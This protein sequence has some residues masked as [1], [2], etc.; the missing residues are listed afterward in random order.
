[1]AD[2]WWVAMG[3]RPVDRDQLFLLPPSMRDWLPPGHLALLVEDLVEQM[4]TSVL[5]R[6][7][8][9]VGRAAYDPDMLLGLLVYGY[10]VGVRSSRQIEARCETDVAFRYLCAQDVPDHT[11]IARFRQGH[12]EALK[13]LLGGVLVVAVRLGMGRFG[14]IAIDGTKIEANASKAANAE[15]ATLRRLAAQLVDESIAVDEAEDELHG[16]DRG[17][18]LPPPVRDRSGR[19]ER[20]AAALAKAEQAQA[21]R[22]GADAAV[23][24]RTAE[25]VAAAEQA[26]AAVRAAQQA[27]VDQW[28]RRRAEDGICPPGA[29]P[30][31]VETAHQVGKATQRVA[32]AQARAAR[33]AAKA[34]GRRQ[35]TANRTDPDSRLLPTRGG[36]T[37]G[38][39]CMLSASD[40]QLITGYHIHDNPHDAAAFLPAMRDSEHR[41]AHAT[42]TAGQH[43]PA[44][45]TY[46]ADAGFDTDDNLTAEGPDRLIAERHR[47]HPS[48]PSQP[49]N[50][51]PPADATPR[52]AMA[53]RLATP[54]GRQ[55]Y[56]RRATT[57]EPVNAHLKDRIGLRRFLLRG[58][59]GALT[60]LG[61]AAIAHNIR[62]IHTHLHP[63]PA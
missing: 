14:H 45:R 31:P 23:A 21:D 40:D 38:Y 57:I 41:I 51:P 30:A 34:A 1:M 4:D 24:A 55:L 60:E 15:L 42:T 44:Q 53:H 27:K 29:P 22:D 58:T 47:T 62:K 18:E 50:G 33:A 49:A 63:Q 16:G 35:P 3:Y 26:L 46:T 20:I 52:Q 5:A 10:A 39:N 9:G 59:T 61:L 32:A 43:L 6:P 17:D 8:G 19:R 2:S 37:Q 48:P 11:V 25:R 54:E 56:Q 28:Q 7:V 13:D 36:Y 12:A